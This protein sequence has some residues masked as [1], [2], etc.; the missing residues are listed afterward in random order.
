MP[1]ICPDKLKR[2]ETPAPRAVGPSG[3][4]S[5]QQVVKVKSEMGWRLD[6]LAVDKTTLRYLWCFVVF[7]GLLAVLAQW[8]PELWG[9]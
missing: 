8:L 3:R 4:T 9:F 5:L 1:L 2:R 6:H 7:Y